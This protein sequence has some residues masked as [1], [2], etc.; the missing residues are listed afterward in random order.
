MKTNP[1]L[2]LFL[3][4][5]VVWSAGCA[6][7]SSDTGKYAL[8]GRAR[9]MA[10]SQ[11]TKRSVVCTG[12]QERHLE[13]GRLEV[14]ANL[15]N[16]RKYRIELQ[17]SCVFKDERGFPTNDEAPFKHLVLMENAE[18]GIRFVSLND[19]ARAYTV[20]TRRVR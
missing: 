1:L 12:I 20:R 13:D 11:E 9:Y 3:G 6:H 15:R 18:E 7:R 8:E 17:V 19:Q 14:T 4:F 2:L 5:S 10:L 16:R